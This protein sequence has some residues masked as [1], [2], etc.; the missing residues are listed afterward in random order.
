MLNVALTALATPNGE[1]PLDTL[2]KVFP[3]IKSSSPPSDTAKS[4]KLRSRGKTQASIERAIEESKRGVFD[5]IVDEIVVRFNGQLETLLADV[6]SIF[7][8]P[9]ILSSANTKSEALPG[10]SVLASSVR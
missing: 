4:D 2:V 1:S 7:R 6:Q 8:M 5:A 3:S 10:S 9:D